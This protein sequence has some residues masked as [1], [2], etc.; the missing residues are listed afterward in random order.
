MNLD[1]SRLVR[2]LS[3]GLASPVIDD[4]D[5]AV[6]YRRDQTPLLHAGVPAA[7]CLPATTEE[8]VHIVRTARDHRVPVVTRGA[9]SGLAGGANAVDGCIVLV[10]TRMDKILDIDE[11]NHFAVVQPGVLNAALKSACAPLGLAYPP[12]PASYEFSTLGGN[13]ATNAGGLCCLKYGVTGDYTIALEVVLADGMTLRTGRRTAKSVAGY[14]LTSLFVG[15]E[16][17]LGIVT[18]ATLRLRPAVDTEPSTAVALLPSLESAGRAVVGIARSGVTPSLLELMDRTTIGA[19]E[20]WRPMGLDTDAAALLLLQSD[21]AP[22]RAEADIARVAEVCEMAGAGTVVTTTD[23]TEGEMLLAA[24]RFAYPAL[25][26][27]GATLLDDVAVPLTHIPELLS[28]IERAAIEHDTIIGT[29]GHA[30]DGNF[31]PTLLYDADDDGSARS[32]H[33]AFDAVVAL[34]LAIP[35][36]GGGG[37]EAKPENGITVDKEKKT[38]TIDAKIA[39]RKLPH[40]KE[41]YPIEVVASLPHPKGKKAHETVVTLEVNPSEVHKAI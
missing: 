6:A 12:D 13:V 17:T 25:E 30:G 15:S 2:E 34:A 23:A 29:F 40:L 39:P 10:T 8:V 32:A 14:D 41:V 9:G 36:V 37:K 19:V 27:L 33:Q 24:R 20:R 5:V 1:H 4:P 18:E 3:A 21:A 38:I 11:V 22:G 28:G 35:P 16:G 31:H 7:V 26:R